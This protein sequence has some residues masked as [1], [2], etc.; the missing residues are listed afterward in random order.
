METTRMWRGFVFL[1]VTGRF[2]SCPGPH[3]TTGRWESLIKSSVRCWESLY[4]DVNSLS[5]SVFW[6]T[7]TLFTPK[8]FSNSE[9]F[10]SYMMKTYHKSMILIYFMIFIWFPVCKEGDR[11]VV[12]TPR[13]PV[14]E[15][16]T[17][18]CPLWRRICI[19]EPSREPKYS[20]VPSLVSNLR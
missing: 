20:K 9:N 19:G 2:C 18:K 16:C 12:I 4:F 3:K 8:S 14:V 6:P 15:K 17:V 10:Y 5:G 11:E 1:W 7:L 13:C